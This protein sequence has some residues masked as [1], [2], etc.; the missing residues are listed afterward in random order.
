MKVLLIM[1]E[2]VQI[3]VFLLLLLIYMFFS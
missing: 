2:Q 1:L 3:G